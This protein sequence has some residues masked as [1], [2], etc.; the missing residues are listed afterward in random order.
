MGKERKSKFTLVPLNKRVAVE[1]FAPETVSAGGVIIPDK[2]QEKV[3]MDGQVAAVAAD[4]ETVK[5]GDHVLHNKYDGVEVVVDGVRYR[6]IS[7][8]DLLGKIE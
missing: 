5:V 7:E 2:A 1:P 3:G 6:M 4:C 8:E